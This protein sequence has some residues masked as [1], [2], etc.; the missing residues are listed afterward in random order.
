MAD[1]ID[2]QAALELSVTLS[3]PNGLD[4]KMIYVED[5]EKLPSV[6]VETVTEFAD[7]CRECGKQKTAHW[8]VQNVDE[9]GVM[10]KCDNCERLVCTESPE[11]Y[12][13]C[14]ECGAKMEDKNE[15]DY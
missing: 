10:I 12:K 11:S 1:L 14:P 8:I 7:R 3:N 6:H 9:N 4:D 2:R 5:I 15:T 13:Y